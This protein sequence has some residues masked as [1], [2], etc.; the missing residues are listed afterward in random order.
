MRLRDCVAGIKGLANENITISFLWMNWIELSRGRSSRSNQTGQAGMPWPL[1]SSIGAV[2]EGKE[3]GV[4]VTVSRTAE[5]VSNHNN[6]FNHNS[7]TRSINSP[8]VEDHRPMKGVSTRS[9]CRPL[10]R[11][12]AAFQNT[13][14]PQASYS[15]SG[16]YI[17]TFGSRYPFSLPRQASASSDKHGPSV[18]PDARSTSAGD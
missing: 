16:E 5:A 15:F 11:L 18:S 17:S 13:P 12:N 1:V 8:G 6:I 10:Y 2:R 3:G 4:E 9:C 7:N 14:I